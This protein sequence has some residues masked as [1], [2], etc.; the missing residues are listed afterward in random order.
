MRLTWEHFVSVAE[1]GIEAED[2]GF[3][4]QFLELGLVS[5]SGSFTLLQCFSTLYCE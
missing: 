4:D 1:S 2:E 3:H 5:G